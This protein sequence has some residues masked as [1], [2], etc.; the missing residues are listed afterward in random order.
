MQSIKDC[1]NQTI[2][3]VKLL[4]ISHCHSFTRKIQFT[5]PCI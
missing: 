4:N 3:F 2:R 5:S 1:L